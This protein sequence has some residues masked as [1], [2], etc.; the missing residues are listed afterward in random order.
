MLPRILA[1]ALAL[2]SSAAFAADEVWK[3]TG[4]DGVLH[5]TNDKA[6]I[7]HKHRA[8]AVVTRGEDLGLVDTRED[9]S[10]GAKLDAASDKASADAV[11]VEQPPAPKYKHDV[12]QVLVFGAPWCQP[13]VLLK[14]QRTLEQLVAAHPG[15]KLKDID[16]DNRPEV[17]KKYNVTSLPTVIFTDVGGK[18]LLRVRGFRT[19]AQL[20]QALETAR[21]GAG[22]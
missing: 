6:N 21:G 19:L 3:W 20:E 18:E 5:Y 13:C 22:D 15:L 1:L 7:P 14:K 17:A 16:A 2:A 8:S 12:R 10:G 4:E 11:T 9:A